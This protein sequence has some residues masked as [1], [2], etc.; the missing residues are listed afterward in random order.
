MATKRDYYEVLDLKREADADEIKR[1]YRQHALKN[2]PDKNPGDP[3][4]ERRFKEAAEAYEVLSDQ[5]KR[6]R[7]GFT[8]S[9]MPKTSCRPSPISSAAGCSATSSANV[10]GVRE[11][12]KIF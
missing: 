8:T 4:A 3:D 7:P 11:P 9:A 6:Q 12:V 10:G 5:A 2:H 1:A